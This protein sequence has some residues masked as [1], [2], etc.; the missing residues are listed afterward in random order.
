MQM[1][2]SEIHQRPEEVEATIKME[3]FVV[4]CAKKKFNW[5]DPE[6]SQKLL[7]GTGKKD[8]GIVLFCHLDA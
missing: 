5:V 1:Y 3:T 2:V 4:K 8:G 7:N 6:Q